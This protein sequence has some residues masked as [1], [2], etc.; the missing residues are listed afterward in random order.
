VNT[1]WNSFGAKPAT[2]SKQDGTNPFQQLV[3][4]FVPAD[5]PTFGRNLVV[6]LMGLA[7]E[8]SRNATLTAVVDAKKENPPRC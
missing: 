1:L 5:M 4:E 6:K 2:G 3:N 8:E 7:W